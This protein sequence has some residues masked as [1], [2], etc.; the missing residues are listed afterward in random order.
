MENK[1]KFIAGAIV[2]LLLVGA[3]AAVVFLA[4]GEEKKFTYSPSVELPTD[5]MV[6][7]NKP[8]NMNEMAFVAALSSVVVHETMEGAPRYHPMF[9]LEDGMLTPHQMD[10]ISKL[11]NG[12]IPKMIFTPDGKVPAG[13]EG[14]VAIDENL[15]FDMDGRRLADFFGYD[16]YISVGS[17]REA[18]WV[19][20]LANIQNKVIIV[21]EATYPTQESVW[22]EL[23]K[24]GLASNMIMV[25]N[26]YDVNLETLEVMTPG[27]FTENFNGN[28]DYDYQDSLFHIDALSV[29]GA[30]YAAYHQCYVITDVQPSQTELGYMNVELNQRAIGQYEMVKYVSDTYGHPE[31]VV[32]VGSAAAV[33]QFQMPDETA[34][35]ASSVEGDK[36]VSSDVMFGFLDGDLYTMDAAVG[37]LVNLNVQALSNQMVR[38]WLYEN[39]DYQVTVDYS[40]GSKTIDWT[41]HGAAFSGYGI[42]YQR[43]QT[44][45]ARFICRDYEDE[46]MEYEYCGP[47]G[48]QGPLGNFWPDPFIKRTD[49]ADM[50]NVLQASTT[51]A[52][53]GHGSDYGSLYLVPY[54]WGD[55]DGA[56]KSDE[57][58]DMY[59]PPQVAMFVSCMNAKIHGG[60][61]NSAPEPVELERLFA[62]NYQ[63]AGCVAYA[64]ATEVSFSNIGQ[65][66]DAIVGEATGDHKWNLNDAW[67]AFFWDGILNHEEEH[68]TLGKAIQWA[69]NRYITNPAH[70]GKFTPFDGNPANFADDYDGAHWKEVTMFACYGDPTFSPHSYN[71][72]A[73]SYDPWHNGNGDQ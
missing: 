43:R 56:L 63:A 9:I 52:Y 49:M 15:V 6:L 20:P 11:S 41:K 24:E 72:G 8:T 62:L 53:R 34:D 13:L 25:A 3:I 23:Q 33:P 37:R 16:G 26:P 10:T 36:L 68:G 31:Y 67:F 5:F 29:I 28:P 7:V 59:L 46:G 2:A 71:P 35:S 64:G 4:G 17:Y 73:G 21:D 60:G 14:Q 70:G 42:T 30:E 22:N 18:L 50:K 44:T 58:P 65:D 55:Q 51:V 39:I 19:S 38:T 47:A 27:Y 48:L 66:S 61:W 32:M 40:D 57:L 69:E 45:P 12:E 54:M 1:K